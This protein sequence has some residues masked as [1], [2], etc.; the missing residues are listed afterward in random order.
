MLAVDGND[1]IKL[2]VKEGPIVGKALDFA[3]GEIIEGKISNDREAIIHCIKDFL[4]VYL[5]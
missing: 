2:G 5:D 3:L 4:M 1:I